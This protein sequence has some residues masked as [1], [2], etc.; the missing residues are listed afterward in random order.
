MVKVHEE[1]IMRKLNKRI[2]QKEKQRVKKL[3]IESK[4]AKDK[5]RVSN[6]DEPRKRKLKGEDEK[7][8]SKRESN[9]LFNLFYDLII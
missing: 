5:E 6:K 9:E 2:K 7:S 4:L 1:A 3:A 8:N